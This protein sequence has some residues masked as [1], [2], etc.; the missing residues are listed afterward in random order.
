MSDKL[1]FRFF[2]G[3]IFLGFFV[4][5]F[6]LLMP[7]QWIK[8]IKGQHESPPVAVQALNISAQSDLKALLDP[9]LTAFKANHQAVSIAAKYADK[10]QLLADL[11]SGKTHLICL[12]TDLTTAEIQ[13]LEQQ[14]LSVSQQRMA[15]DAPVFIIHS[16]NVNDKATRQQLQSLLTGSTEAWPLAFEG[17]EQ[18]IQLVFDDHSDAAW[19]QHLSQDICAGEALLKSEM[20]ISSTE[21]V[22]QF[23]VDNVNA[24]GILHFSEWTQVKSAYPLVVAMQLEQEGGNQFV[25]PEASAIAQKSYPFIREFYLIQSS[26]ASSLEDAFISF[27][28]SVEGQKAVAETGM[29]PASAL[30]KKV[31]LNTSH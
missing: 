21:S 27:M 30:L 4:L 28:T 15:L 24:V 2:M 13:T 9:L 26:G 5:A 12:P 14:S 7:E 16:S 1:A 6:V 20:P 23:V 22:A 31:A 19:L 3:M 29:T 11:S 10:D 17:T 25:A 18:A 8:N